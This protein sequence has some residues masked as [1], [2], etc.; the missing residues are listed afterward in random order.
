MKCP[1]CKGT[2]KDPDADFNDELYICITCFG[3]G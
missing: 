2:G 1:D 3:E